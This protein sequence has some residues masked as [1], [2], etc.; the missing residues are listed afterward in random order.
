MSQWYQSWPGDFEEGWHAGPITLRNFT[1]FG[2]G[3]FDVT[4]NIDSSVYNG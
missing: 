1:V 4:I 2:G 3:N